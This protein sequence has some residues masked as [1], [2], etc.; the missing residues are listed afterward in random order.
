MSINDNLY[1]LVISETVGAPLIDVSIERPDRIDTAITPEEMVDD[2][3]LKFGRNDFRGGE[4]LLFAHR[5]GVGEDAQQRFWRSRDLDIA[6]P[7]FFAQPAPLQL[8]RMFESVTIP[9]SPRGTGHLHIHDGVLY[10][11]HDDEVSVFEDPFSNN[12]TSTETVTT[13]DIRGL[14]SIGNRVFAAC[15]TD[16]VQERDPGAGT[17]SQFSEHDAG[18]MWAAKNTLLATNYDPADA[19][20]NNHRE[21]HEVR[22]GANSR[23][24]IAL[25][26]GAEFTDV[27]DGGRFIIAS[28]TDGTL[29]MFEPDE[30]G[31]LISVAEAQLGFGNEQVTSLTQL[32]GA[33]LI[34]TFE[35]GRDSDIKRIWS[36]VID[37]QG[38][39]GN[40]NYLRRWDA[41]PSPDSS[42]YRGV[43]RLSNANGFAW[44]TVKDG[45]NV[46]LWNYSFADA[47]LTNVRTFS[48][49]AESQ[50][51][52]TFGDR[53][54]LLVGSLNALWREQTDQYT[55]EGLF[56]T[57]FADFFN[58]NDKTWVT[59]ELTL[60]EFPIPEGTSI[61][62]YY[63]TDPAGDDTLGSEDWTRFGTLLPSS[64]SAVFH[65]PSVVSRYVAVMMVLRS[66]QDDDFMNE[67]TPRI[68]SYTISA[69]RTSFEV[70]MQLPINVSNVISR[71][72]L[73]G[74]NIP[75]MGKAIFNSLKELEGV[76]VR[77]RL[78][79]P[80]EEII[81]V[82]ENVQT[83]KLTED[84]PPNTGAYVSMVRIRGSRDTSI[85][86]I[87]PTMSLDAMGIGQMGI[88]NMGGN[89]A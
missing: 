59:L 84:S 74:R 35:P 75:G 53:T 11:A 43:N 27:I 45:N 72:G 38:L 21:L 49:T 81:G 15:G 14:T 24:V 63:S 29:Y 62:L 76:N 25:E 58:V 32:G 33:I 82:V 50:D 36:G 68:S 77:A 8:A 73:L 69:L 71:R 28:A 57:P 18:R 52:L 37:A 60:N 65:F 66:D 26:P 40:L 47:G 17:W 70:T 7:A 80:P 61:E 67:N 44:F 19:D 10:V 2:F 9:T 31:D 48:G 22:D 56:I 54:F 1:R 4:G 12:P 39:I 42:P 83:P 55:S 64:S 34:G 5:R 79:N 89:G 85:E 13:E 16:G 46:E 41:P 20:E 86:D 87:V 88:M 3:G 6:T 78:F 30:G 23:L 51:M